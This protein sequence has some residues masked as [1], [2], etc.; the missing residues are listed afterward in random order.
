VKKFVAPALLAVLALTGCSAAAKPEPAG[1]SLTKPTEEQRVALMADLAKVN[2][3]LEGPRTLVSVSLTCRSILKGE[4]EED[5][6]VLTR[7]RISK[8]TDQPITD[9]DARRIIEIIKANGF[10]VRA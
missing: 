2:P 6:V 1:P 10:C 5:Q 3:Q 7:D 9:P 8:S 4:S